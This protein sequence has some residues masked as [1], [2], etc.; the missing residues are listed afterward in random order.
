MNWYKN[1]IHGEELKRY[2]KHIDEQFNKVQN[3]IKG[4]STILLQES[5]AGV[6]EHYC[7][8]DCFY[9][10]SEISTA[11]FAKNKTNGR[12]KL[13]WII[14]IPIVISVSVLLAF[15]F[16]FIL[17]I[18]RKKVKLLPAKCTA[19]GKFFCE[20]TDFCLFCRHPAPLDRGKMV[21]YTFD[22]RSGRKPGMGRQQPAAFPSKHIF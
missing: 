7:S 10:S 17:S 4:E 15:F 22:H 9:K 18:L 8:S 21:C 5:L 13:I 14:G 16:N 1:F 20:Q 12:K 2:E 6:C 3:S 19:P 11:G